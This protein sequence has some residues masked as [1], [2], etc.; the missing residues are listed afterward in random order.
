MSDS[1]SEE[2]T[3]PIAIDKAIFAWHVKHAQRLFTKKLNE[4][5]LD[6]IHEELWN[7]YP[8]AVKQV[9]IS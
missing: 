4:T 8:V 2:E 6:Q 9:K 3:L 1:E 5:T 7:R